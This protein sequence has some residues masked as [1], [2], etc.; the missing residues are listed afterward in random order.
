MVYDV[1]LH[2][3]SVPANHQKRRRFVKDS[4]SSVPRSAFQVLLI[5]ETTLTK[6]VHVHVDRVDVSFF[7][8]DGAFD[9]LSNGIVLRLGSD[10][11][12]LKFPY[13]LIMWLLLVF[14]F[15]QFS[16]HVQNTFPPLLI[17]LRTGQVGAVSRGAIL[18]ARGKESHG[19]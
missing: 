2:A 8:F 5:R 9:T 17:G 4:N 6:L 19:R 16:I 12:S 7:L 14:V 10:H 18:F 11:L 3:R 15:D 13:P 1:G